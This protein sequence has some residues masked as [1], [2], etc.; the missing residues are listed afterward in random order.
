MTAAPH[1]ADTRDEMRE[2]LE[3]LYPGTLVLLLIPLCEPVRGHH[4]FDKKAGRE[5][6]CEHPGKR[7]T[8]GAWNTEAME[9]LAHPERRAAHID[10]MAHHLTRG[11]NVGL[12]IPPGVVVF[13]C[14]TPASVAY[15]DAALEDA[16]CQQSRPG[17][18]HFFARVPSGV[19]I[20]AT[21]GLE[22]EPGIT[23]D[24]RAGGRSQIVVAPSQHAE[25]F[26]YTWRRS[27]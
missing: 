5:L 23:V 27:L 15:F 25:G 4:H 13:D 20:K 11:G 3:T 1:Y 16:P 21:V 26:L 24:V 7:P 22:I 2:T 17:R 18:A 6:E 19:E 14:D 8:S 12:V 10:A 9:R